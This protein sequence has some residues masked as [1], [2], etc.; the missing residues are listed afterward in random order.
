MLSIVN[1]G[2]KFIWF[3]AIWGRNV[4]ILF[5]LAQNDSLTVHRV[6]FIHITGHHT[7]DHYELEKTIYGLK[8]TVHGFEV[9]TTE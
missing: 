7:A 2:L 3:S 8:K 1:I 9:I 5:S 6:C 4:S